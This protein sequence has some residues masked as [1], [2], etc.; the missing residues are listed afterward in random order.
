VPVAVTAG[1]VRDCPAV[2]DSKL[3]PAH[4]RG[5]LAAQV[6]AWAAGWSVGVVDAADVDRLGVAGALRAAATSAIGQLADAGVR[7]DAVLV[8]GPVA[9]VPAGAV[10]PGTPVGAHIR[11]D[12]RS[13]SMAAASL[14]AKTWR[15]RHMVDASR[16]WP[17]WGLDRHA[18]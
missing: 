13:V 6:R 14:V 17:E 9:W 5:V 1:H 16:V 10:A 3:V 15:D 4:R 18:G 12:G 11:G 8:D 2:A 7:V